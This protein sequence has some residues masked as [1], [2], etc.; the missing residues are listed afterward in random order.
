M[1]SFNCRIG[2]KSTATFE[3]HHT[4]KQSQEE[5]VYGVCCGKSVK[6]NKNAKK[7]TGRL[8]RILHDSRPKHKYTD[9]LCQGIKVVRTQNQNKIGTGRNIAKVKVLVSGPEMSRE[10]YAVSGKD[11]SIG[12]IVPRNTEFKTRDVIYDRSHDSE[13][14]I[15]EYLN[16]LLEG[17]KNKEGVIYLHS[18][19]PVCDSC[20]SVIDQFKQKYNKIKI[21]ISHN[22]LYQL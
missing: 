12:I 16:G 8:S 18:E 20:K 15:F 19:A 4:G 3:S 5:G 7:M 22:L 14:K 11:V 1:D 10:I 17:S 21:F 9:I 13:V 2:A 6:K